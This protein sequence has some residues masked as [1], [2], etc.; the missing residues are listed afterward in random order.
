MIQEEH[1]KK[2]LGGLKWNII[3]QVIQ[4]AISLGLNI[5][6][7]R[8][9]SPEDFGL[10]GMILVFTGFLQVFKDF[11]LGSA[12]IQRVKVT[13][14]EVNTVFWT[15]VLVGFLLS[16]GLVLASE[17][18]GVFY[19][20]SNLKPL[21]TV[22]ALNFVIQAFNYVH[23][24]L[25]KKELRFRK[26]F[27][28]NFLSTLI[29]GGVAVWMAYAGYGVWSIV[30]QMLLNTVI[31]TIV[32]WSISTWRPLFEF[33]WI[34]LKNLMRFS[35][36]LMGTQTI[37]YWNRNLDNLLVGKFLGEAALGA[38]TR[39]YA[40]MLFPVRQISSMLSSVMFPSIALIQDDIARVAK[41]YIKSIR[42]LSLI[43]FPLMG[44]LFVVADQ[45]VYTILGAQW[46]E[47]I[48]VI[49]ILSTVG[50]M[51]S[52][53]TL[54]GNI[55]LGLGK[56][57][58]QLKLNL[59]LGVFIMSSIAIG[60]FFGLEGVAYGYLFST[61][62]SGFVLRYFIAKLLKVGLLELLKP[63]APSFIFSAMAVIASML[64]KQAFD[65][66]AT[67]LLHLIYVSL[68]YMVLVLALCIIFIRKELA[69][70]LSIF[71]QLMKSK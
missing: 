52:I 27:G 17:A 36:P 26:L 50:A 34:D 68:S 47:A 39:A 13:P 7:A 30:V 25:L 24:T 54:N 70:T 3:N 61:L 1:K 31:N 5:I 59:V 63:I 37:H 43:N 48:P 38:Y 29:S 65:L 51:Q 57:T 9:L 62:I 71:R 56:T 53:S 19:N 21:I 28:V 33:S 4:Q 46:Y 8:L 45:F 60:V 44:C 32:L 40:L 69:A 11:G 18:I 2:T 49:R 22:S 14:L 20:N 35:L 6:L 16:L 67:S 55:F 58:L 41:L 23:N 15:N 66:D 10:I 64:V 12:L 42:I